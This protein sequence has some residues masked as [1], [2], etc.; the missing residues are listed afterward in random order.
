M[1]CFLSTHRLP[2]EATS[3]FFGRRSVPQSQLSRLSE[4]TPKVAQSSKTFLWKITR[5]RNQCYIAV[6]PSYQSVFSI[7]TRHLLRQLEKSELNLSE[8]LVISNS[9]RWI[10]ED[11]ARKS[12]KVSNVFD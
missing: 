4:P 3:L 7:S 9:S 8:N 1:R 10:S 11:L 12:E 2:T 6:Q 5:G